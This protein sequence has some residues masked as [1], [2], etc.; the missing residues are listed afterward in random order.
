MGSGCACNEHGH[1]GVVTGFLVGYV[2]AKSLLARGHTCRRKRPSCRT[3]G[4]PPA[5]M[6][7]RSR[8]QASCVN[9]T[10]TSAQEGR[11][12]QDVA[13]PS[14]HYAG[15]GHG[16]NMEQAPSVS[17][18]AIPRHSTSTPQ[19][20]YVSTSARPAR[21]CPPCAASLIS[22]ATAQPGPANCQAR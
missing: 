19:P 14:T 15:A 11:E 6:A 2:A 5:G 17:S 8:S 12:L 9:R 22:A 20:G 21:T 7:A 1:D 18:T 3:T 16:T 13:M 4:K 10:C